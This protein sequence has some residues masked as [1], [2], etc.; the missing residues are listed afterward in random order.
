M[1][2]YNNYIVAL[3]T[4]QLKDFRNFFTRLVINLTEALLNNSLSSV[5]TVKSTASHLED[6]VLL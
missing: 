2:N 4:S 6:S 3:D 1:S 5:T